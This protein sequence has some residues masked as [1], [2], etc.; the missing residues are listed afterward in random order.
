MAL[1]IL[2]DAKFDTALRSLARSRGVSKS[3]V[4]RELVLREANLPNARPPFGVFRHL[5]APVDDMV[6]EL[7]ELDDDD[8]G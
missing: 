6:A 3:A 5:A 7:K 1:N 4:I 8:L 2:T